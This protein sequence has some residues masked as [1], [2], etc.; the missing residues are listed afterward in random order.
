MSL[1]GSWWKTMGVL[2]WALPT[3]LLFYIQLHPL[4]TNW[5]TLQLQESKM[6]S[7]SKK[8]QR[9]IKA[10]HK[11]TVCDAGSTG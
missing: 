2:I 8:D 1:R 9:I 6:G 7:K 11:E 4:T 3:D 5:Q 10:V